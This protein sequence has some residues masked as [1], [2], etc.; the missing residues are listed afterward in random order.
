MLPLGRSSSF[1]CQRTLPVVSSNAFTPGSRS[2][3]KITPPAVARSDVEIGDG[4]RCTHASFL[5]FTSIACTRPII[6]SA[7]AG[8][9]AELSPTP[10]VSSLLP[11]AP[12]VLHHSVNGRY[13]NA[14]CALQEVGG[15][16]RPP[17]TPGQITAGRFGS[18]HLLR[19]IVLAPV[20]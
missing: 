8:C 12:K 16:A 20:F 18:G 3:E 7:L 11:S 9:S 1:A 6:P 13:R 15:Q 2:P 19:S 10:D 17:E 4:W 14:V 5:P